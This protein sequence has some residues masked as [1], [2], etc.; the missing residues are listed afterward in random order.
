MPAMSWKSLETSLSEP[1][2]EEGLVFQGPEEHGLFVGAQLADF[3]E[4]EHAAVGCARRPARAWMAPVKAPLTW[5]KR[6]DMAASPRMVAQL[7]ST[8]SPVTWRRDF[9]SS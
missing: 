6:A 7:T 9:L 5:P 2:G 8:N 3:V 1:S 4:E